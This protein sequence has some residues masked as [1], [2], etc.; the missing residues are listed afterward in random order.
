MQEC[1]SVV[2]FGMLLVEEW[3]KGRVCRGVLVF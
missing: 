1:E 3:R 2:S